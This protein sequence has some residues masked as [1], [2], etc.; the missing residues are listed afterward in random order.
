GQHV[1]YT[2]PPSDGSPN[3]ME[4]VGI[5][6][7]HR[8]D[9]QNDTTLARLFVPFA[10]GYS[11]NVFLHLRLNTQDQRAVAGMI[12]T[13]RQSLREIDPDVPVLSIAPYVNLMERSVGLWIV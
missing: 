5:V 2:I 7:T 4:V 3:D 13:M 6:N 12:P 8:H 11:G 10:Q 1:R 9:V